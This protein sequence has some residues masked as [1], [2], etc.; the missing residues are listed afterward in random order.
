MFTTLPWHVKAMILGFDTVTYLVNA[1]RRESDAE[2]PESGMLGK[3]ASE[4]LMYR[5]MLRVCMLYLIM[6]FVILAPSVLVSV[7]NRENTNTAVSGVI[8]LLGFV[9]YVIIAATENIVSVEHACYSLQFC[10]CYASYC[11]WQEAAGNRLMFAC[12][13]LVKYVSA[14]ATYAFPVILSHALVNGMH[15]SPYIIPISFAGEIAGACSRATTL[16]LDA[17]V[18]FFS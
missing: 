15:L 16:A 8:S 5:S 7:K 1:K 2:S 11:V 14:V 4:V 12:N 13:D 9:S 17:F 3:S 10:L 6:T 18:Q